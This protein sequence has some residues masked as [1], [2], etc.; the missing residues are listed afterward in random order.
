[1]FLQ[2]RTKV[3]AQKRQSKAAFCIMH[4]I[5]CFINSLWLIPS[6]FSALGGSVGSYTAFS[7]V[8]VVGMRVMTCSL[9]PVL[10][11][12]GVVMMEVRA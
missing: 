7:F 9:N 1:M 11:D 2:F 12:E 10:T 6:S 5:A 4:R 8:R 3:A